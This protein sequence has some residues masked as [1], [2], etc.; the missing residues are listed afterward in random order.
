MKLKK[1][2]EKFK[3]YFVLTNVGYKDIENIAEKAAKGGVDVIQLR[4]KDVTTKF[5]IEMALKVKKIAHRFR[6]PF[7]VNDRVDVALAVNSDGVHLG[8]DDM[9]YRYARKILGNEKIIGLSA[10]SIRDVKEI[11]KLK[12]DYFSI[13][14]IFKTPTKIEYLPLGLKV[15]GKVKKIAGKIKWLAVGG[16]DKNNVY[17]VRNK[18]VERI[19]VVRAITKSNSIKEKVRFFKEVLDGK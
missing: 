4:M 9:D 10:H 15:L 19:A 11:V 7:I 14:P 8:T 2:F 18:G 13:G 1:K 16:I 12:P 6:I 5:Y 17:E 3:V